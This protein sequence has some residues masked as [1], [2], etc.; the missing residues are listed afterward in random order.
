M[1][2]FSCVRVYMN[3][4]TP[5]ILSLLAIEAAIGKVGYNLILYTSAGSTS[6]KNNRKLV[7]INTLLILTH[8]TS[9]ILGG[10][11]GGCAQVQQD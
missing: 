3:A 2:V 4:I 5:S 1:S 6:S 7:A 10:G 9:Q 8:S 11:G